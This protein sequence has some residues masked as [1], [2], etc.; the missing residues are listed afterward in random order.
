M[1][2][3]LF[4]SFG[5]LS[6]IAERIGFFAKGQEVG[7]SLVNKAM[8]VDG[9]GLFFG[10]VI[11]SNSV[12]CYIES[13]T[14]VEAGARTGFAS[15]VTGSAFF[16]SLLF[17]APFVGIIPDSATTCALVMVGVKTLVGAQD[18]NFK[19]PVD[20]FVGFITIA[21]MGFTYSISNGICAGFIFFSWLRVMRGIQLKVA[22]ATGQEW[23]MPS[24][25]VETDFPHPLML[26]MATFMVL[27]FAYLKA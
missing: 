1:F 15:F 4:D 3:E 6:A 19:D 10:A 2:V 9:T 16:L 18:I 27:R 24:K 23:M 25:D 21:I 12:T 20:A 5:T 8:L 14:G 22:E 11:G 13:M 17:V 26:I 7:M